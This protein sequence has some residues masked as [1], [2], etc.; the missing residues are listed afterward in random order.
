[1][2]YLPISGLV[3]QYVDSN[4][5]AYSGAVLKAYTGGTST[6]I[7]I[8]TDTTGGT[9][10]TSVALNSNGYPE[11]SGSIIIPHLDQ[12]YK[13]ALY[14]TQAAA[15]ANSGAIWT[16]DNIPITDEGAIFTATETGTGDAYEISLTLPTGVLVTGQQMQFIA[17][18]ANV[19]A[20]T[21]NVN[22]LGVES[23]K[24]LDG[25]DPYDNAILAN[26]I[27]NVQYDGANFQLLNP[28]LNEALLLES[29]GTDITSAATT[30]IGAATGE[31]VDVTG[32]VTITS[33]GTVKAGT[34]RV[35]RFTGAP[36][37]TH[38]AT[39]LILPISTNYRA[40]SGDII[41]F[42]SLGSG[43]WIATDFMEKHGTWIPTVQDASFSDAEGQTYALNEGTY[44]KIWTAI[45]VY[46]VVSITSLGT[47]TTSDPTAITLPIAG[48]ST[49][50]G[51]FY[52][53]YADSLAIAATTYITGR[54][55]TNVMILQ[56]WD[57][58]TGPTALLLSELSAT[59]E[60]RISG[61]YLA[62]IT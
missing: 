26:M 58:T 8:A 42:R 47:L 38:N 52:I 2:S 43:N 54:M 1:M 55:L 48:Q 3:P 41:T 25:D 51:G 6:N 44:S 20:C 10:A 16:V 39:S 15:D 57:A 28:S 40:V 12:D 11:V 35:I 62:T 59:A 14:P 21:L 5:D 53:S 34:K 33:L 50:R 27:V 37:L 17:S 60:I 46:G 13:L 4:S 9:L 23:I 56:L 31:F 22:A 30:D 49:Y 36:L 32:S 24:L 18:E 61:Q 29:K 7:S 45:T 19:G